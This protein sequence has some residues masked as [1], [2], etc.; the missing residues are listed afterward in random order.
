LIG[1][2]SRYESPV[3]NSRI[4]KNVRRNDLKV[5]V[6]GTGHDYNFNYTH[7]GTTVKTLTELLDGV[8]P[9]TDVLSQSQLPMVV[10][11]TSVLE[12]QDGYEIM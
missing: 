11:G 5:G 3:L 4:I 8:H 1:C 10:V 2:N 9:Y 6:I 7:L 12:R